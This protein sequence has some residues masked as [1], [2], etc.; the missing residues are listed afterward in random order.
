MTFEIPRLRAMARHALPGIMEATVVPL[1]LFYVAMWSLGVWGAL[2][3]S[4][5]WSYLAIAARLVGRRRIPGILVLGSVAMTARALVAAVSGS[6]F[7]YFLQPSLGTILV[8]GAFLASV[9]VGAPLAGRLA[10]DFCPLPL[11]MTDHPRVRVFF[12][13]VSLLWGFVYLTNAALT[14]WLLFN[15]SLGTFLILKTVG[16]SALTAT[17]IAVSTTWFI[18]SMRANGIQVVRTPRATRVAPAPAL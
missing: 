15:E 4:V 10:A 7:V 11:E 17:A 13:R 2:A 14:L 12:A 6:V 5:G 18:R 8:A 3:A 1:V 16:S 9:P